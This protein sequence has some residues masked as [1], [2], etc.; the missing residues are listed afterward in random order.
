MF[1]DEVWNAKEPNEAQATRRILLPSGADGMVPVSSEVV[2]PQGN[3]DNNALVLSRI[4]AAIDA[5]PTRSGIIYFPP[6]R[7]YLG[8]RPP[9]FPS[10]IVP[11]SGVLADFVIP[12]TVTLRFAPGATLI[13]FNF[14]VLPP[15]YPPGMHVNVPVL[16]SRITRRRSSESRKVRLEIRG[17]IEAGIHDIFDCVMNDLNFAANRQR[18]ADN[19]TEAGIVVLTSNEIREVY[20]E[21]W[22][23]GVPRGVTDSLNPSDAVVRRTTL[24]LQE[25]IHAAHTR[26][27][28]RR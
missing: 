20:P 7:Y 9:P 27:G 26:R 22:G 28:H 18:P 13:P 12:E 16:N 1:S 11:I 25:A 4:L 3:A 21:W 15:P 14:E 19:L 8:R 17:R 6:G 2:P 10:G 23:A 24:A 5:T